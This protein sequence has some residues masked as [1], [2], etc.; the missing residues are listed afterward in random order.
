[1]VV[2]DTPDA[3]LVCP[4]KSCQKV[5]DVVISLKDVNDER[6]YLQQTV[7]RPWGFYTILES[8]ERH[9]I[10]KI[11]V[12]PERSLSLQM[13]YHRS[14]HWVVVKGMAYVQ[15]NGVKKSLKQGESTFIRSGEKHRL[16]N[17]CKIPLEIIEV[18]FGDC[19]DEDDILRF[20]DEY[21]R[22]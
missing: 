10:K 2:V 7:Y 1:M 6:A 16:S 22:V 8:S 3:M 20:D 5:K 21:G 9:K 4:R 12:M 14:E 15:V 18:Q 19:V 17:P 11:M 13:H